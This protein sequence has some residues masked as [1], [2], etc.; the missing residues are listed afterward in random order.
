MLFQALDNKLDCYGVYYDGKINYDSSVDGLTKT[1]S[2][3]SFIPNVT[4]VEYAQ[5][6]CGGK[7]LEEACPEYAKHRLEKVSAKL[8]AFLKSFQAAKINLDEHCFFEL[9]P[10]RFL[11][12]FCEI[13]NEISEYVF[14]NYEKPQNYELMKKIICIT[15]DISS[16]TLNLDKS[17]LESSLGKA[18]TRQMWKDFHSINRRIKY[19]PYGTKT[20]R[21]STLKNSFPIL[22]LAKEHRSIIK[23]KNDWLVELDFNAAELRTLLALAGYEQPNDDIHIW[24]IENVYD[25]NLSREDAKQKIFAWLYNP[26][27]KDKQ[28]NGIYKRDDVLSKY[29]DG[30]VIRTP[31]GRTIPADRKHALNYLIQSTSSDVFLDRAYALHKFLEN[32]K[33]KICMLIHDSVV[34]D[35]SS[36]DLQKMKEIVNLFSNT[37]LGSYRVG[38]RAGKDFGDLRRLQ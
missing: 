29:W 37:Q 5:I 27:S 15:T 22:T 38:V 12:E 24:N 8:K 3:S 28:A 14:E 2:Y 31:F 11:V 10:E 18:K 13:K 23:P 6:Y 35:L 16:Q 26:D 1:W 7:T 30:E 33:S 17:P 9:V 32:S 25:N 36:E 4:S 34:I 19:N 21:L 20:G